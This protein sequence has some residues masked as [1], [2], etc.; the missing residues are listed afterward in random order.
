M[1]RLAWLFVV[2]L[3]AG[4]GTAVQ[5]TTPTPA[6]SAAVQ[7]LFCGKSTVTLTRAPAGQA[8]RF[9]KLELLVKPD[10]VRVRGLSW[11]KTRVGVV[12][13]VRSAEQ[14]STLVRTAQL[15]DLDG[16]PALR[17]TH[18]ALHYLM[19][20]DSPGTAVFIGAAPEQLERILS[21]VKVD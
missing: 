3:A 6:P 19:W 16:K 15:D 21:G 11:G 18:N 2:L 4:C 17:W 13:G 20:L 8:K 7:I 9:A 12:C 10:K 14:F 5:G 1:R